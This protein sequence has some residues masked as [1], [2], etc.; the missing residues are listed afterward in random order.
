MWES[1]SKFYKLQQFQPKWYGIAINPYYFIRLAL[2]KAIKSYSNDISS[3]RLLDFGCGSKPYKNLLH[4]DEYIG[5]DMEN[6]GH[7]HSNED[8]DVYYDGKTIPFPDEYFDSLLCSE[9]LEH[10]F[11]IDNTLAELSR[12]LK[13]EAKGLIT[14]PFVWN[15]H[16]VPND[17]GRYSIFGITHILEKHGFRI[18]RYTKTTHFIETVIQMAIVY[19]YQ[20]LSTKNKF[21]NLIIT[22]LIVFPLNV[23]SLPF[24]IFL[25]RKMDFYHNL[26]IL[27]IK[28]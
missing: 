13:P 22:L 14:I 20:L 25:P 2:F 1:L 3:G 28:E 11:D 21:I 12:V 5:I 10:V 15:E 8:V 24:I 27:I 17:F 16:E 26:A 19:I 7:S 4:V 18:I 9:V 6:P 23:I